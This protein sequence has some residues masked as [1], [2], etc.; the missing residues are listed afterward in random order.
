MNMYMQYANRQKENNFPYQN[1]QFYNNQQNFGNY[2]YQ[3]PGGLQNSIAG[4]GIAGQNQI[5]N[6]FYNKPNVQQPQNFQ[7]NL[8]MN[9]GQNGYPMQRPMMNQYQQLQ[10]GNVLNNSITGNMN[11]VNP[12]QYNQPQMNQVP[13][14][15]QKQMNQQPQGSMAVNQNRG[16]GNYYSQASQPQYQQYPVQNFQQAANPIPQAN[17]YPTQQNVQGSM[18]QYSLNQRAMSQAPNYPGYNPQ[19]QSSNVVQR[20]TSDDARVAFPV[21]NTQGGANPYVAY[22]G[23]AVQAINQNNFEISHEQSADETFS[24]PSGNGRITYPN[25][26]V[27]DGEWSS[28]MKSGFGILYDEKGSKIYSGEWRDDLF[29]GQGILH[30]VNARNLSES[31]DFRDMN[32]VWDCWSSYEGEFRKGKMHGMGVLVLSNGEKFN[33]KFR[34]GM[35]DGEGSFYKKSGQVVLG[36]WA[37]NELEKML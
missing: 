33:G 5:Q 30:N 12:Q 3:K 15:P 35:V 29:H 11:R 28:H 21:Q 2:F 6:Q 31:F 4:G 17:F 36:V 32:E 18:T 20:M 9:Q 8:N 19:L 24:L 10:T 34:E 37:E 14:M 23:K 22:G 13:Q 27:Y 26:I 25:G 16:W 1:Q 7:Q